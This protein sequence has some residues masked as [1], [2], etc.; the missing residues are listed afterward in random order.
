[1][2]L[3]VKWLCDGMLVVSATSLML[4]GMDRLLPYPAGVPVPVAFTGMIL[5]GGF[6]VVFAYLSALMGYRK[7]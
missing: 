7:G 3:W 4:F 6:T 2:R 5:S 1:M